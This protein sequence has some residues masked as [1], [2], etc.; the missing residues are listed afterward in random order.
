MDVTLCP[1]ISKFS[2]PKNRIPA[3]KTPLKVAIK[4]SST[5]LEIKKRY[6]KKTDMQRASGS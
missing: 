6:L 3:L 2:S 5:D 4:L 1:S